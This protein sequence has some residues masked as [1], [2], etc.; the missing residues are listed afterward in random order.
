MKLENKG[1]NAVVELLKQAVELNLNS[2]DVSIN[3]NPD[4]INIIRIFYF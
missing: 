4:Y 1:H 3:K 2:L